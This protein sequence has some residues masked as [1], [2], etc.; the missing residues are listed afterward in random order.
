MRHLFVTQDYGP[1]LGGIARRHV[2]LCRRFAPDEVIVSTVGSNTAEAFDRSEP[3]AIVREAFPFVEAKRFLN[4][5]RWSQSL[6]RQGQRGVGVVHLGNVRPCGYAVWMAVRRLHVPYV[7][8]VYGGDVLRE[9]RKTGASALKRATAR[10]ILGGASGI[11][12]I[13][14]WTAGLTRQLMDAIG[15][16]TPPPVATVTL[17][18]DPV[19]FRPD[20]D[21]RQLRA[22]WGVGDDPLL[23]TVAR[24]VPHKGQD[25]TIRALARLRPA[26]PSL[27]Y[28][29]VGGGDD[30]ARL[31]AVAQAEGVADRVTF[32]GTLSDDE[33]AEAYATATIYVGLSRVHNEINAE[34]FGLAFVE[35]GAS[36]VP[37]VAGDSG[38]VRAAVRDGE[39]GIVVDPEDLDH[40]VSALH[41][42]LADPERRLAMGAAARRAVETNFNWDRVARE[43]LGFVREVTGEA[44]RVPA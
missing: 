25:V 16:D 34:G 3:Y 33:I 20:N 9:L 23:L 26:F 39:T 1:D 21:R 22:R 10:S 4:Q 15:L 11:V 32:A 31:R 41:G 24:L 38:G 36:G 8:Y 29:V 12:A 28:V 27:R 5:V 30:E 6:V 2:E 43:T 40:V 17:G 35:A 42:L 7:A 19:Q 18:T 13:S 14:D 44:R 37:S